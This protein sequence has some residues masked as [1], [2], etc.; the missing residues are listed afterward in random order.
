MSPRTVLVIGANGRL[1]AAAVQAFAAAG[2]QVLAQ[3]RRAPAH[4]LPTGAR[5]LLVP[6]DD[7]AALAA[8]AAGAT[9]VVHAANPLYT[10]WDTDLMPLF[11]AALSVARQLGAMFMMPG[12]VYNYGAAHMPRWIDEDTPQRPG[13][14]K[15]RWRV[16]IEDELRAAAAEGL[17]VVLIRAGDFF[18]G[19]RGTWVDQAIAKDIA[20]GRLVYP[21][22]PALAHAWAYVPD[23]ARAF[24]AVADRGPVPGY[25]AMHF[26]GHTLT[27]DEFLAAL[28]AAAGELGLSPAGGW[29][30]RRFPWALVGAA[31]LLNPLLRELWRMRY[32]WQ[33]PHG[34]R[35]QALRAAAGPLAATPIGTALRQT[36]AELKLA[37]P[38]AAAAA[39][40][41]LSSGA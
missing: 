23:L 5:A 30:V 2:W 16:R 11:H 41:A 26:A 6:V 12:S 13:T 22:P 33:V 9:V 4:P 37:A 20:R 3:M 17:P 1:G 18:G 27:G 8:A 24:A 40:G 32:L 21:G 15:G 35:G 31:G 25:R 36:L 7:P 28:Q 39:A 29:R 38:P 19:G 34:L 14:A 10:R